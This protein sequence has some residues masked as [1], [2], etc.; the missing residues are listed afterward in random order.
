MFSHAGSVLSILLR[1][2]ARASIRVLTHC[3]DVK[4]L[5]GENGDDVV[6]FQNNHRFL[7]NTLL[8]SG[9]LHAHFRVESSFPR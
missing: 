3:S 2:G 8:G 6:F 1:C 7:R 4:A 5:C 9:P